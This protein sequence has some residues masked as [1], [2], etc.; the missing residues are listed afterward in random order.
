MNDFLDHIDLQK[1]HFGISVVQASMNK[2]P[3]KAKKRLDANETAFMVVQM[4]TEQNTPPP[5]IDT[6]TPQ[7]GPQKKKS[8]S[9]SGK[10]SNK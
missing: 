2:Q 4:M 7:S 3:R 1:K 10:D 8:R 9:R 5:S 6:P